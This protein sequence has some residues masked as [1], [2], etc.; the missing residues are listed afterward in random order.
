MPLLALYKKKIAVEISQLRYPLFLI[1]MASLLFF[2]GLGTRDF[3]APVEPRYAEIV[4]V[5]LAKGEWIIP[6]VNGNLYTDKPILYFWLVLLGSTLAGA[7]NE[8]TV[9]LPSAMSA[10]GLVVTTYFLGRDLF[11]PKVG[12]MAG[13]ILATS[14]RVVWEARWAHTDMAFTFLFS[15]SL[16]FFSRAIFQ[17]GSRKKFL[18][19]YG[20]MG[21]ATLTKGLIG[22]VLP[23]LIV[24]A[25]V[26]LRREWRSILQ[27]QIPAGIIVFL[28]VSGPWFAWVSWATDGKWLEEFVLTHH[29]Q[30]YISGSGH[31]QPV[32]YYLVN[33]PLDFL[34]W[35]IFVVPAIFAYRS[36]IKLLK[37]PVPL[38]LFLWFFVIFLFFSFSD[39]K[40]ALYLLPVF[41]PAALF[42][43]SYF[44]N[45][46]SEKI[47]Q[48]TL[49]HWLAHL[50]FNLLWIGS[51]SLPVFAWFFQREAVWLSLPFSLVMAGGA[52]TT[53][54]SLL[55]RLSS[56]VFFSTAFTV[57]A[58][59]LYIAVWI[60][61]FIDQYKSPRPFA[62]Q[63]KKIVPST[64][65]LYIYADIMND[66]NFYAERE[67]IPVLSSQADV[68][69]IM[70]QEQT[71]YILMRDRD[72]KKVSVG[73]KGSMVA[74]GRVG[75]KKW[76]LIKVNEPR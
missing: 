37:E 21:L 69:K 54:V 74:T 5:M 7:V 43:A 65:P 59:M 14:A 24:L 4:R 35:A 60:L 42:V 6:T 29:I 67:V 71:A 56:M 70:A 22:I 33:F 62:M 66:F 48:G 11:G 50:F 3:W 58:G 36:R 1:I 32:F 46:V 76:H 31:R 28:W 9:R 68:E 41:P 17:K 73:V 26:V 13:M 34:P 64:Q 16:Y 44:D 52:L 20:L 61:P 38:F 55:R 12:F 75:D 49:Y 72:L 18:L 47:S 40:R 30:R 25:F 39:T 63:I 8:W 27:W 19:A 57:L 10:L 53:V 23:V 15:L 2:P 45:L 51:L